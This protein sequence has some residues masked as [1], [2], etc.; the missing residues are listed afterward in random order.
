VPGA[1]PVAGS[2][3]KATFPDLVM[4]VM[5]ISAG[6]FGEALVDVVANDDH[7]VV[8][9]DQWMVRDGQR[10]EYRSDHIWGIKNG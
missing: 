1:A 4:K 3:T 8:I 2:Y 10:I 5:G 6:T 7:A 9:L